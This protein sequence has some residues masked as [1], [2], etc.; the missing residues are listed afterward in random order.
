LAGVTRAQL[1]FDKQPINYESSTPTERVQQ[2]KDRLDQ[3]EVKFEYDRQHGFLKSVLKQLDVPESSQ[4]LVF[5]KTSSQIRKITPQ[6]PRAI[7]FNDDV[8]VG[9]VQ[10]GGV[11]EISSADPMLG[12]VFFTLDQEKPTHPKIVRDRGQCLICHASSRTLGV[13]GHLMRSV[14]TGQS[15]QPQFGSGT[16]STDDRSP[17]A[18]RWGG[19]YVTGTHGGQRHMGNVLVTDPVN[20]ENL[21]TEAGANITKLGDLVETS[22]YLTPHSDIV[23]LLVLGHQTHVHNLITRANFETRSALHYDQIM[24]KALDRE[25]DYRSDSTT[26]RI[27]AVADKL[28]AGLL[29]AGET[30]LTSEV[31]GTSSYA[32]EFTARGPSDRQGRSLRDFNLETRLMKYPC[33]FL[34]YSDS[35]DA[36][37]AEVK[38]VVFEQLL[39]VLNGEDAGEGFEHL[40][41]ADRQAILDILRETKKDLPDDWKATP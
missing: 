32:A 10:H 18:E 31:Q 38:R 13:P 23:S 37:P 39:A 20:N 3:G 35:F 1:E 7:Y 11:I 26:R 41:P 25:P 9:W 34:I 2:L 6:R 14:Y 21:D 27:A 36:L 15:G 5:S 40:S 16:F 17:F 12:A 8:Y 4:L 24:N 19:W 33:S 30:K 22:P 28:V 29:F